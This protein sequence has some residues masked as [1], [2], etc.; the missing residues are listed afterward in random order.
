VSGTSVHEL[1]TDDQALLWRLALGGT[2]ST[3]GAGPYT[4]VVTPGALPTATIQVGRSGNAGSTTHP[5]NYLACRVASWE[6]ACAAG[7]LPILTVDWLGE[8]HETSTALETVSYSTPTRLA[9]THGAFSVAGSEVCIDSFSIRGSNGLN[10]Q[11]KICAADAGN[12]THREADFRE[13]TGT[14]TTDFADLTQYNRLINST[15]VALSL[16]FT[17]GSESVTLAGN[18]RV[19]ESGGPTIDGPGITKESPTFALIGSTDAAAITVTVINSD[20]AA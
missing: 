9:F 12:P 10:T 17:S 11:H 18:M 7:E 5:F 8:E 16:A 6:L 3:T 20:S 14:F 1:T 13:V 2:V 19:Q 4:H 15:E